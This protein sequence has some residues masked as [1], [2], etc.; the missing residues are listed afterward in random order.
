MHDAKS[1]L[2]SLVKEVREGS[3]PEILICISGRPAAKIVPVGDAPRRELG[4]D[5][6]LISVAP[7]FDSVDD[8]VAALFEGG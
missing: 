7:D 4:V 2:S 5:R 8:D 1:R 6:G 3:E